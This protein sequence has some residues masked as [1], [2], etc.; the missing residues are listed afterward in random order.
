MNMKEVIE[1]AK[2]F[3]RSLAYYLKNNMF[4][5]ICMVQ[6]AMPGSA[7][8]I[9]C[10]IKKDSVHYV[11]IILAIQAILFYVKRIM[12]NLGSGDEVPVPRERFTQTSNDGEVTVRVDRT[13]ELILYVCDL[14][15]Y[16]ER[17]GKL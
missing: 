4:V 2:E 3:V 12:I 17:K 1:P 10:N 9:G 6:A 11:L 5:I 15:N 13:Q 14:E 16:L 8:I 7:F